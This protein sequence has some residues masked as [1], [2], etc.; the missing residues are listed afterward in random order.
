MVPRACL[1]ARRRGL[2]MLR[3]RRLP[4]HHA[5][6]NGEAIRLGSRTPQPSLDRQ[7]SRSIGCCG[8]KTSQRRST[9]GVQR[10]PASGTDRAGVVHV[11]P[12]ARLRLHHRCL[13]K[14]A[15]FRHRADSATPQTAVIPVHA[16]ARLGI[17]SGADRAS[18]WDYSWCGCDRTTAWPGSVLYFFLSGRYGSCTKHQ[19]KNYFALEGAMV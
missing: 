9:A 1:G 8:R 18:C 2:R 4:H 5:Q 11:L 3:V 15:R 6:R 10:R 17:D 12:S 16:F 19:R 13:A 14:S 7:R